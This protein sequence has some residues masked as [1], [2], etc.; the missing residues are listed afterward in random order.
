MDIQRILEPNLDTGVI[1]TGL[2]LDRPGAYICG[3]LHEGCICKCWS[4][5][6]D[7]RGVWR[8]SEETGLEPRVVEKSLTL[9]GSGAW[10]YWSQLGSGVDLDIGAGLV[11]EW[12][13]A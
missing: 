5:T 9:G 3:G 11:P 6:W 7:C 2:V 1:E 12:L 13:E 8:V 10:C 4:G